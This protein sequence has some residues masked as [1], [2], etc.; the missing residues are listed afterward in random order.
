MKFLFFIFFYFFLP[1]ESGLHRKSISH[2]VGQ[3]ALFT[4][5]KLT[6]YEKMERRSLIKDD[7]L[8]YIRFSFSEVGN[9]VFLVEV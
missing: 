7:F 4:Y 8:L 5:E 9:G 1:F 2:H 3:N 6:A